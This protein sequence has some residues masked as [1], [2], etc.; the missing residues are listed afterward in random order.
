MNSQV[1]KLQSYATGEWYVP[2]NDGVILTSSISGDA[3][4]Q[5]SSDGL[6]FAD[7][8]NYARNVGGP[9][10]RKYTFHERAIMLKKLAAYLLERKEVFYESSKATGATR[11]DSWVDIEGG[12]G[13]LFANA[14][15]RKNF[16]NQTGTD[17]CFQLSVLGHAGK[18]RAG[19][20]CRRTEYC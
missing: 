4:A 7:M 19:T 15:H 6:D 17:K 3:V 5:I 8:L 20:S 18:T 12:F 11:S 10:L 2:S 1:Y 16:P 14:S 9:A 13:N